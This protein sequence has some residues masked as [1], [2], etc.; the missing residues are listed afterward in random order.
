METT[1]QPNNNSTTIQINLP[2]QVCGTSSTSESKKL[3]CNACKRFTHISCITEKLYVYPTMWYC[4]DKCKKQAN[5]RISDFIDDSC[6]VLNN[7]D[8][9]YIIDLQGDQD[10]LIDE[11]ILSKSCSVEEMADKGFKLHVKNERIRRKKQRIKQ[12]LYD[13]NKKQKH[14]IIHQLNS[15]TDANNND[16]S[17]CGADEHEYEIECIVDSRA[18]RYELEYKV[19]WLGYDSTADSWLPVSELSNAS[20]LITQYEQKHQQ[21]LIERI[22]QSSYRNKTAEHQNTSTPITAKLPHYY[23]QQQHRVQSFTS[24]QKQIKSKPINHNLGDL[25]RKSNIFD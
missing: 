5:T 11:C 13:S 24:K 6:S 4:S 23:V 10:N 19:H 25:L 15:N 2:C 3:Q 12:G 22:I 9:Q 20:E 14:N 8:N 16:N 17:D 7:I 21:V 1:T 18:G